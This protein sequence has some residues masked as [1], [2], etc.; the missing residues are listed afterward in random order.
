MQIY[1]TKSKVIFVGRNYFDH[2]HE[3]NN[4]VPD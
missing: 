2:I 1:L 4:E 3:Y